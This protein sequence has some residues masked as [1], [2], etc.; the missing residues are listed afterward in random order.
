MSDSLAL[1][2]RD[3]PGNVTEADVD[4][5]LLGG[6]DIDAFD[7]AC[8]AL[9]YAC[10]QGDLALTMLL[11]RRGASVEK[12]RIQ[13]LVQPPLSIAAQHS[14]NRRRNPHNGFNQ[15]SVPHGQSGPRP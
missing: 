12:G 15:Q 9:G 6:A 4:R 11:L 8:T 5:L 3:Q 10:E 14:I 7:F 1:F 2:V 13:L